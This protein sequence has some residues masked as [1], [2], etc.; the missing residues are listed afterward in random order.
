[1]FDPSNKPVNRSDFDRLVASFIGQKGAAHG[2]SV[3]FHIDSLVITEEIV[4]VRGWAFCTAKKFSPD[5]IYF[6]D[7]DR[8]VISFCGA[9]R[10]DVRRV[11]ELRSEM[12]GFHSKVN[13]GCVDK[14]RLKIGFI[15]QGFYSEFNLV[16]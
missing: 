8:Y 7:G 9:M 11:F 13:L 6:H 15:N 16:K 3:K 4:E 1:M 10:P 2:D 5:I 12:V 14:A